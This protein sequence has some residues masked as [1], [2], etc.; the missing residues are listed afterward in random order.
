MSAPRAAK[1]FATP[2]LMPLP[3]PVTN[4][5]LPLKRSFGSM[6]RINMVHVSWPRMDGVAG[7]KTRACR[8]DRA[9]PAFGRGAQQGVKRLTGRCAYHVG[10]RDGLQHRSGAD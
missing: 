4:T 10:W 8:D 9:D 1:L 2:R 6:L 3:P 7:S 5:V